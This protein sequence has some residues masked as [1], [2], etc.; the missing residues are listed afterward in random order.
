MGRKPVA[1]HAHTWGI[2]VDSFNSV[3]KLK[4]FMK[5]LQT[6]TLKVN[7][8]NI[9]YVV[10][11]EAYKYPIYS[12]LYHPEYQLLTYEGS[13]GLNIKNNWV[14]NQIAYSISKRLSKDA[15]TNNNRPTNLQKLL[16]KYG[17]R[18][19]KAQDYPLKPATKWNTLAFGYPSWNGA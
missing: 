18:R 10:S 12:V 17:V 11:M 16:K 5:I 3:P 19:V 9:S 2:S 15:L 13:K 4:N 1:F 6:D 8:K 14:T 7:D